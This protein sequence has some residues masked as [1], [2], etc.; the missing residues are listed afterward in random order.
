MTSF[1]VPWIGFLC[2]FGWK[3]NNNLPDLHGRRGL[4]RRKLQKQ[5]LQNLVHKSQITCV[6]PDKHETLY[7]Q[8]VSMNLFFYVHI[9]NLHPLILLLDHPKEKFIDK[10]WNMKHS[11][12]RL[13]NKCFNLIEAPESF[14][15]DQILQKGPEILFMP[16]YLS[17]AEILHHLRYKFV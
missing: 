7:R 5:N 12:S 3:K 9:Q 8:K 4:R 6:Y 1:P 2:E 13:K 11:N 10:H 14:I 17:V 15:F 16:C